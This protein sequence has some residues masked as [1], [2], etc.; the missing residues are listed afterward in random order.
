MR[1]L[2][3]GGSGFVGRNLK[4]FYPGWIY[5]SS[6]DY[7]L[8]RLTEAHSMIRNHKPDIVLHLAGRVGGIKDNAKNQSEFFDK[9]LMIN[10]N[11]L[12]ACAD[13]KVDRVLSS[14]STCCFPGKLDE[15]RYPMVEVD[16]LAGPPE[17]TNFS[18]AMTKRML[19]AQTLS[20]RQD[21]RKFSC[22]CPSNL[23]GPH[24]NFGSDN[25]HFVAAMISK[26]SSN[27][28]GT[29]EPKRQQLYVRDLCRIIPG[30]IKYWNGPEPLIVA[31]KEN[32]SIKQMIRIY[33]EVSGKHKNPKFSGD[34]DGQINKECSSELFH[35]KFKFI[36]TPFKEGVKQTH[37]W[38]KSN[39]DR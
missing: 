36:F 25:S 3:T 1:V 5:I 35:S 31:P 15:S 20:Y 21:G 37:D 13:F 16:F 32:L 26:K 24:D 10:F 18:Y 9:N 29:G 19:Y 38:Y 34:L 39:F 22:F 14:L 6:N 2:V 27:F 12:K 11:V 7:D 30:L 23:Y 4:E 17:E 8:E 28:F 33:S